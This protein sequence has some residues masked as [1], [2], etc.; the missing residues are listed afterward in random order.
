M[1]SYTDEYALTNIMNNEF[2]VEDLDDDG[3]LVSYNYITKD[4]FRE[5]R[6]LMGLAHQPPHIRSVIDATIINGIETIGKFEYMG[7]LR[8]CKAHGMD[9]AIKEKDKFLN[10]LSGRY[11]ISSSG[12]SAELGSPQGPV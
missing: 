6:L 3:N 7:F 11:V 5:N 12:L 8:F 10:L 2:V 9:A 1:A 4:L